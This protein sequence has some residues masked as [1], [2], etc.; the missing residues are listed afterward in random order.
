MR[1]GSWRV[2]L[3]AN[4][5]LRNVFNLRSRLYLAALVAAITGVGAG[6]LG[7]LTSNA[8]LQEIDDAN[9]RG[10]SVVIFGSLDPLFPAAI[11]RSSCEALA[12]E[13]FVRAAGVI[14]AGPEVSVLQIGNNIPTNRVSLSLLPELRVSK[15]VLGSALRPTGGPASLVVDNQNTGRFR[16]APAFPSGINLNSSL[17]VALEP[18]VTEGPSCTVLFDDFADIETSIPKAQAA[19]KVLNGS[20]LPNRVFVPSTDPVSSY[21]DGW[22]K[23]FP[24][25]AGLMCGASTAVI[26]SARQSEFAVYRVSGMSSTSSLLL[27]G[28]ESAIVG[29]L[30]A[31]ASVTITAVSHSHLIA[32]MSAALS[33]LIGGVV[34]A[35][36]GGLIGVVLAFRNPESMLRNR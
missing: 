5:A 30:Y 29:G 13:T 34:A 19:L 2:S 33:H 8:A 26:Q 27:A 18:G 1:Q 4:E 15:T 17:N 25:A 10:R 23:W 31:W 36:A 6:F 11:D 35:V 20:V 32:P 22:L 7:V 24:L 14:V 3:I 28:L 12:E 16:V 21:L 9:M